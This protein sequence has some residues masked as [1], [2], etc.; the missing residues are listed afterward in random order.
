MVT[1]SPALAE[2]QGVFVFTYLPVVQKR[3]AFRLRSLDPAARDEAAQDIIATAWQNFMRAGDHAWQGDGDDRTGKA[4]PTRIV[5]H[6]LASYLGE[7]RGFLGSDTTDALA[8]GTRLAGRTHLR[9]LA[10]D[11]L[12]HNPDSDDAPV[13]IPAELL[14][15]PTASPANRVRVKLDWAAIAARCRPPARRCLRLLAQGWKPSGIARR[16]GV[17][18]ARVTAMKHE[19]AAVVSALG[20]GPRR[21]QAA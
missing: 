21:W 4:T 17:S 1:L 12:T 19:I 16:L 2:S 11:R 20:Y 13:A 3:L 18:P 8:A 9:R 7:G 5:D 14:T 15:R 6:A 10:G